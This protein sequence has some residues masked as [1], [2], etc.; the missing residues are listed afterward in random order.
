MIYTTVSQCGNDHSIWLKSLEFYDEEF[1]ILETRLVEIAKKNNRQEAMAGVEH[2]QNQFIV[3]RNNIDE[4]MHNINEH[5][6]KVAND[7]KVHA[8]KIES[9]LVDEHNNLHDQF[10]VFEKI[11][12]DLRLEYN[13]FLAKWM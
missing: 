12:K 2:F 9:G 7:V 10:D 4:L 6:A 8:G 3:Q 11:V 13:L 5:A 1:D